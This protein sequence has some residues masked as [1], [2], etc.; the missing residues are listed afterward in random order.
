MQRVGWRSGK[1]LHHYTGSMTL[2][3][4]ALRL[5]GHEAAG[6]V[7]ATLAI[8][9]GSIV[10]VRIGTEEHEELAGEHSLVLDL[11]DGETLILRPI[12][13]GRLELRLSTLLGRL[14]RAVGDRPAAAQ[15]RR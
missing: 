13:T 14:Q 4:D 1:A 8:P 11:S 5:S 3:D 6:D 7:D 10:G 2:T 12:G 9:L 15:S